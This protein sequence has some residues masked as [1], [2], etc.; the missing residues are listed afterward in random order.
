LALA[1]YNGG[2]T[3]VADWLAQAHAAG[4]R[5]T[6]AAI[7]FPQT[8]AYVARVERAQR[9]YASEYPELA[10]GDNAKPPG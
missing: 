6:I 10:A 1:A 7:R 9:S 4:V 8:R 3:N 5:F 2:Q